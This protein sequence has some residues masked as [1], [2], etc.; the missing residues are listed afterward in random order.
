[1]RKQRLRTFASRMRAQYPLQL[2]SLFVVL[3]MLVNS[4]QLHAN[5]SGGKVISGQAT[6]SGSGDQVTI[7]QGSNRAIINWQDFSIAAGQSASFIQPSAS[8]AMLNR[9]IGGNASEIYGTLSANG[10]IY[11][12][13]PN[14]VLVGPSGVI[15]TAGFI[16]STLDISNSN[17]LAGGDLVFKGNSDAVVTNLG[18]ISASS[19]DV[20]MIAKKVENKGLISAPQGTASLAAG[21]EVLVM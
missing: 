20:I 15:N 13:N 6:I 17:F 16:A 10:Q 11:L 2:I 14:G 8:S 18:S 21:S 1:M 4:M 3:G 9:V 5:P 12:V 7:R 19:G